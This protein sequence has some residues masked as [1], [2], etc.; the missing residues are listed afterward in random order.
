[1]KNLILTVAT[2]FFSIVLF[3]DTTYI[4]PS[5][6]GVEAGTYDQP[7]NTLE[8]IGSLINDNDHVVAFKGGEVT[9]VN[10]GF[11]V[12]SHTSNITLCSYDTTGVGVATLQATSSNPRYIIAVLRTINCVI[13][14]LKIIG[15]DGY[16]GLSTHHNTEAGIF[17]STYSTGEFTVTLNNVDISY[18]YN[19]LRC[20]NSNG[21]LTSLTVR[22]TYIHHIGE[23]GIFFQDVASFEFLDSK[24]DWINMDYYWQDCTTDECAPGDCIQLNTVDYY[25]MKR[26]TLDHRQTCFKSTLIH[27]KAGDPYS[28]VSQGI[29]EDC[30]FYGPKDTTGCESATGMFYLIC[31]ERLD[32]SR[33]K[34]ICRPGE[35]GDE[36][37]SMGVISCDTSYFNYVEIDSAKNMVLGSGNYINVWDNTVITTADHSGSFMNLYRDL[38]YRNSIIVAQEDIGFYQSSSIDTT[39]IKSSFYVSDA[40]NWNTD[41]GWTDADDNGLYIPTSA[42]D[43]GNDY[44]YTMDIDGDIVPNGTDPERG[45]QEYYAS[46]TPVTVVDFSCDDSTVVENDFV[47]FL[48]LSNNTPTE[49]NWIFEGGTPGTSTSQNPQNIQYTTAG[50]FDVTLTARNTYGGTTT[51]YYDFITVTPLSCPEP[52][53]AFSANSTSV[54]IF[55]TITLTDASTN[56]PL[57]WQWEVRETITNDYIIFS[58]IQN[59]TYVL[60]AQGIYDFKLTVSNNCGSDSE[61][62]INYVTSSYEAPEAAFLMSKTNIEK[63]TSVTF[64]DI[65]DNYPVTRTFVVP[66]A[67]PEIYTD[68]ISTVVFDNIGSIPVALYVWNPAGSDTIVDTVYVYEEIQIE[69]DVYLKL[70]IFNK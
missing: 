3:A 10:D 41:V 61:E 67:D 37:A 39:M 59:P 49:W 42:W 21:N 25:V 54:N 57:T 47:D 26:C 43:N 7:Y 6:S 5:Y 53:A 63:G 31:T 16:E 51:V 19:G 30:V 8:D 13:K 24:I 11:T 70:R 65:S 52:V 64:T 1:M 66:G 50:T 33:T 20:T 62:K 22:N 15:N 55:D 4:K 2:F 58:Y 46:G 29:I 36:A 56:T 69:A 12:W 48:D 44:G 68:S 60:P 34:L 27:N 38:T 28:Y 32:M 18:C 35:W 23:D 9:D 45:S 17:F 14:D 40:G